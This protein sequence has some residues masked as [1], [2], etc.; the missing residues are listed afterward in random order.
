MKQ[1][2]AKLHGKEH[3]TIVAL[4]DSN[5]ELT[6]HTAGRLN[7]VGLL[8]YALFEKHGSNTATIINSGRCGDTAVEALTRL[9]SDVLRF[10]PD[11]VIV[12]FGMNDGAQGQDGLAAYSDAIQKIVSRLRKSC[13]S[14]VL[15]RTPNPVVVLNQP[16]LPEGFTP[17]TEWPGSHQHLYARRT[18]EL[19]DQLECCVVDHYTL[20]IESYNRDDGLPQ[21][22]NHLWNRMSDAT[23]PGA[24]GHLHFYRDMAPFFELR[25]DFPWEA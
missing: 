23:H 15:L 17:G 16:G 19:A 21:P 4:G 1:L 10:D 12:S 5:T 8:Q 25:S 22:T 3:V 18:V 14:E 13:G 7:W 2:L 11:L 24:L 6:W 20:W 9:E